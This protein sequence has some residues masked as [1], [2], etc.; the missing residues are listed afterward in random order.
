[1]QPAPG[2]SSEGNVGPDATS[3]KK[4]KHEKGMTTGSSKRSGTNKGDAASPADQDNAAS[5]ADTM[6]TPKRGSKY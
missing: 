3:G 1:M 4:T 6:A 2:A 5:D